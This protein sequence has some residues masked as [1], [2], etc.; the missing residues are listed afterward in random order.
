M[1]ESRTN[2]APTKNLLDDTLASVRFLQVPGGRGNVIRVAT[3]GS[4]PLVL[5]VHGFPE[6]WFSWR[7]QIPAIAEAGFTAAAM[8]V[9][10]YGGSDKPMGVENYTLLELANDIAAVIDAFGAASA[11]IVGHDWGGPQVYAASIVHPNR[12]RAVIGLSAPWSNYVDK[13]PSTTW[14]GLYGSDFYYQSYF[15]TPG[16]AEAEIEPDVGRFI[17]RFYYG[18]SGDSPQLVNPLWQPAPA[19]TLL[20]ALPDPGNGLSWLADVEIAYYTHSFVAGGMTAPLNRYRAVDLDIE[21][22]RP[23]ADRRIEQPALFIAG[24]RDPARYMVPGAGDRYRDPVPR[25]RDLRGR[26]VLE[27]VGHWIQQE[28]PTQVNA[29]VLSFLKSIA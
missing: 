6:S 7:H 10:G 1:S 14:A 23:Y 18:L 2:D 11:V 17:R 15:W 3:A 16:V 13:K 5:M 8:D 12:V 28:A 4:G 9:R 26:H 20:N 19:R 29:L 21:Q 25:F 27:Q 24:A 22:L